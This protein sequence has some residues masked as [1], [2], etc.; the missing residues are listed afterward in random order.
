MP[1]ETHTLCTELFS[2]FV[3]DGIAFII[4][5]V[6]KLSLYFFGQH[7]TKHNNIIMEYNSPHVDAV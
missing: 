2:S 3:D 6:A 5:T 1:D 4:Y 7:N